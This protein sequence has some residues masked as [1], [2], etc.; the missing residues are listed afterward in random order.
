MRAF[1]VFLVMLLFAAAPARAEAPAPTAAAP[2]PDRMVAGADG[3]PIA[4]QEWGNPAGPPIV[5]I[6]GFAQSRLT[7]QPILNSDLVEEFRVITLDLRGHGLSGKPAD[8]AAYNRSEPWAGD[9]AAVLRA[10]DLER[11]VLVGWSY[12]GLVIGDYLAHHGDRNVGGILLD[13]APSAFGG[14]LGE[15][16]IDPGFFEVAPR[17]LSGDLPTFIDGTLAFVD[18]LTAGPVDKPTFDVVLA[19]NMMVPIYVRKAMLDRVV[20][21]SPVLETFGG[22]ALV[23]HGKED[24]IVLTKSA[25]RAKSLLRDGKLLLLED[26][27][28]TPHLE[29]ADRFAEALRDLAIEAASRP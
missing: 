16:L 6:H 24:R 15:T 4:T 21:L 1:G 19:T 9:L 3:V 17:A 28:H 12:G 14:E 25:E 18:R 20:D 5:L 29:A 11:P 7:W 23:V 22:P 26:V 8:P 10:Y 13:A 2:K 27:G